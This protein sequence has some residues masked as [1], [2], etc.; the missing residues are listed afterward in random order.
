MSSN[1]SS[2]SIDKLVGRENYTT[3]KFAVRTYL[4]HEDLW[5]YIDGSVDAKEA[6]AH[7]EKKAKS[8]I[9][10]LVD[11][12]NYVHIQECT[13]AQQVWQNLEKA[14][15]DS[16]LT[17]KVG[18]LKTL[19]TTTLENSN[20]VEDYINKIMSTAHKL[21]SINFKVDDEWL[22]TLLLAGLPESYKPMLMAL[23]SSGIT[24]SADI[25]KTKILQDV[26]VTP[27]E[28]SALYVSKYKKSEHKGKSKGPRCFNC[29]K[30]GHFSKFCRNKKQYSDYDNTKT[31]YVAAFS[32]VSVNDAY[33]WYIDSGASVHMTKHREWL[34]E[35][36]SSHEEYIRIADDK[37]LKVESCGNVT[38]AVKDVDGS[39]N[40]IQVKNVLFVPE[41]ATNLLSVSKII[42]S[43][44]CVEF[45]DEGCRIKNK[46]GTTVATAN[47]M[48]G[49][50]K[51]NTNCNQAL[52]T[53]VCDSNYVWHQRMGH[54]N[55]NDLSKLQN[56]AEGIKLVTQ[57]EDIICT[58][59]LEG[60]QTRQPFKHE[61]S[62][63]NELL[64]LIHSDMC[65]P[66]EIKSIGGARYFLTFVDDYSRK[67]YVYILCNKYEALEKF[68]EFKNQVENELNKKIKILRS[69]NGKEYI[70]NSFDKFLKDSGIIHQTSNPY[71]PEQNGL[72]ERMNRTLVER[73][74]CMIFNSCL[75]K[76][77]WAEA[78]STAAYIVNRSPSRALSGV[79]PYERWTGSKPDVSHM[80]IFGC[81][82]M[83]HIPK[84]KRLKWDTKSRELI[85]VGYSN[86]TKGYRFIDPKTRRG[87]MSRDVVFLEN[88]VKQ[89]KISLQDFEN[90]L[91]ADKT[92]KQ[93]NEK[94]VKTNNIPGS[95]IIERER[96][97]PEKVNILLTDDLDSPCSPSNVAVTAENETDPLSLHDENYEDP[98]EIYED[99]D[100]S[101][102]L[103]D[104]T[105]E[106]P[107]TIVRTR[108]QRNQESEPV[109]MACFSN[110]NAM[111]VIDCEPQNTEEA[112]NSD[113]AQKWKDAMDSEY[114][115]LLKNNTWILTELP[116]GK[117]ALPC[118]WVYKTKTDENGSV[119]R[120]KARLVVKGY[121]QRK[122][123]D[124]QEVFSPVI[125]YTSL[126]YLVGLTAKYNLKI[127]QMDA[128]TAF[129][130]G[131]IEEE[132]YMI[133]P[134]L[135]EKEGNK[136]CRLIK[137]I[138]GLKQASRQW[139][140]KLNKALLDI[141]LMRCKVDPCIYYL[142]NEM[143]FIA[144]YVDDLL[145]FYHCDKTISFV[146]SK[147]TNL[148]SMKDVG[149]AR[150]CIGLKISRKGEEI[151][152]DQSLY[153]KKILQRFGMADCKPVNTPCDASVKL[154]PAKN[155]NDI[156][157][158]IPYHEAVGCL[159]YLSQ[160]TRP[161][162]TY[163]VNTLS[164]F[165]NKPT[166]EHWIALKRVMRY[167]KGTVDI[168]LTFKK[169]SENI[170]GYCD[171]DWAS[172]IEDRRSCS[173]NV[174][175]FQGAAI[176]WNSKRQLTVALS[177]TEAEYMSLTSAIQEALWLKQLDDELCPKNTA[178]PL[179]VYCDN[180]ST[181]RLS[182]SDIYHARSKHIDVRYHFIRERV[183]N[184]D[185]DV[186][187]KGTDAML[188]DVL[189]KGL[190][191]GK[192]DFCTK[193]MGLRSGED[194]EMERSHT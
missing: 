15:S 4:E 158:G 77:Y 10:L 169:N 109:S 52:S 136:V 49:T 166:K 65:G 7:K 133:Q 93:L 33:N 156:L 159:L 57:K 54:I 163:A 43:G 128:I 34:S 68:K 45:C 38:I 114:E 63:A 8:K 30:Y 162:I 113:L 183:T 66:M 50:Y 187:F 150:Y 144:V 67:V 73:A 17:R 138:Y 2:F 62:R 119:V 13:T 167:L 75:Q 178:T 59:C 182:G 170:V 164:R 140:K 16:G 116:E 126:R 40:K 175:M 19:I 192:H 125:R 168:K 108:R 148:F 47:C 110:E 132:I 85:F 124:Y 106:I 53:M 11:P 20:S 129:L 190:Y 115:S 88:T 98:D 101:E 95:Q 39:L 153:T 70:N 188:A 152:L 141:G 92:C 143:F 90:I 185:V 191:R 81:K 14:F 160:S 111:S 100:D 137:S 84:E 173:G 25:V 135:Y 165:N 161:D 44:C 72:A 151:S 21:R 104:Q 142:P 107:E 89:T 46:Q 69:D 131:D 123:I 37:V 22:G 154:I 76:E 118:K 86:T 176:S 42:G 32:A 186:Q 149:E 172:N 146:K 36:T 139:N 94:I 60:K 96:I 105:V 55:F 61:G 79:T 6:N 3:W 23:E 130:Q 174:F 97:I 27:N 121:K 48:N 145:C 122:D 91:K 26:N 117:I 82:A 56:C 83:V 157:K 18:L 64:E 179:T 5:G 87:I 155:D 102:Y 28:S 103:P 1:G 120:Y 31:G 112:L 35:E 29:N 171:A 74:K 78:V 147:L 134:P 99:V 24:I 58:S 181:I 177:S 127:N 12:I 194:D 80:K 193:A 71:T 51:L 189:T 9:I 184:G 180:Q 41:L